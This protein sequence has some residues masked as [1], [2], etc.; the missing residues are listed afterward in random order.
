MPNENITFG[1]RLRQIRKEQRLSQEK[2]AKKLGTSKQ[3]LSRYETNQ[4]TPKISIAAEYAR[5][6]NI[7]LCYM[8]GNSNGISAE[9]IEMATAYDKADGKSRDIAR[10]ALD[11]KPVKNS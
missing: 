6:L 7:S 9:A 3:I 2:F 11:L 1:D 10:L 5:K 8:L 4:R